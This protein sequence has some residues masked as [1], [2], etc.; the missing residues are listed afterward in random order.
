MGMVSLLNKKCLETNPHIN[1]TENKNTLW[2]FCV[3]L[4]K[5]ASKD[6]KQLLE[7]QVSS[8]HYWIRK[9]SFQFLSIAGF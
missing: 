9:L 1:K 6:I 4:A 7:L 8:K 5:D 2:D 3:R